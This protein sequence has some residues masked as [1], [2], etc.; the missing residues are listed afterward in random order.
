MNL[1]IESLEKLNQTT[2]KMRWHKIIT[3]AFFM[4]CSICTIFAAHAQ[5]LST[6]LSKEQKFNYT[7]LAVATGIAAYGTLNWDY[8]EQSPKTKNEEWFGKNSKSGGADKLGHLYSSYLTAR[9]FHPLYVEWGFS[10]KEAA[11]RSAITSFVMSSAMEIGDGT[12]ADHGF[13]Y[14]DFIVNGVG[15]LAAYYLE[16][17]PQID[18]KIDLR[19]EYN[20]INGVKSDI[21]T[22]YESMK[23]L[24]AIKLA[25]FKKFKTTPAKYIEFHL[26][27][28][29]RNYEEHRNDKTRNL[30][31]GIGINLAEILQ[32][33]SYNK[34]SK[35]FNY[36]QLPHSYIEERKEL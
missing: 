36:Y 12:S 5:N 25:G 20:P 10:K 26:G 21:V 8:F 27:Y 24:A 6:K 3:M 30:Y 13:S 29:T 15:Q 1:G 18:S 17:H 23:Y 31:V 35:I 9:L 19:V 4:F 16:T 2:L 7:N 11:K 32:K 22:D 34:T 28:Y 14:E 33:F